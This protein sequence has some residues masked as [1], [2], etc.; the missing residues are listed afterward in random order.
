MT[1]VPLQS[2]GVKENNFDI[3]GE[4]QQAEYRPANSLTPR[5]ATF[6]IMDFLMKN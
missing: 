2:K 5:L 4:N 3:A 1:M 6:P